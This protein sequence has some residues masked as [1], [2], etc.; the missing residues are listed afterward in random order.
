LVNDC[1]ISLHKNQDEREAAD[2]MVKRNEMMWDGGGMV[3]EKRRDDEM[4]VDYGNWK[5]IK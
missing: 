4:M 3:G 1:W 5:I 2:E